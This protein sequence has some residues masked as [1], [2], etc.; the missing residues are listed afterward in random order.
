MGGFLASVKVTSEECPVPRQGTV[1]QEGWLKGN[2]W[3]EEISPER[4]RGGT[5]ERGGTKR[6]RGDG[7]PRSRPS[8]LGYI[9]WHQTLAFVNLNPIPVQD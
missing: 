6:G 8:V 2:W 5:A 3:G 4:R 9:W 1:G 7:K